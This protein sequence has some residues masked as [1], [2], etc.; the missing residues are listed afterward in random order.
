MTLNERI[1]FLGDRWAT[2]TNRSVA[3]LGSKLVNDSKIIDRLRG[4]AACTT[5]TADRF[6]GFFRDAVNWPGSIV[7]TDVSEQLD[8]VDLGRHAADDAPADAS[9]SSGNAHAISPDREPAHA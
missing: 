5:T 8:G 4:G 2:A 1:V 7:P 3:T 6:F 9:A